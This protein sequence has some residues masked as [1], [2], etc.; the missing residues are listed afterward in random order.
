MLLPERVFFMSKGYI[1]NKLADVEPNSKMI[2]DASETGYI[3]QDI[4]DLFDDFETHAEFENI[5]LQKIG[6]DAQAKQAQ[7]ERVRRHLDSGA[8]NTK[9]S[10][11]NGSKV[12][13]AEEVESSS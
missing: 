4:L 2:I 8:P 12:D 9:D 13:G 1:Q 6:F 5:E 11:L 10:S 7:P 3:D